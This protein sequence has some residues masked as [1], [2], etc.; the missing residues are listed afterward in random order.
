MH[1]VTLGRNWFDQIRGSAICVI[2]VTKPEVISATANLV[3]DC[4]IPSTVLMIGVPRFKDHGTSIVIGKLGMK[5]ESPP[6]IAEQHCKNLMENEE[7]IWVAP[8][9]LNSTWAACVIIRQQEIKALTMEVNEWAIMQGSKLAKL[10]TWNPLSDSYLLQPDNV[11]RILSKATEDFDLSNELRHRIVKFY[12]GLAEQ[13]LILRKYVTALKKDMRSDIG[14]GDYANSLNKTKVLSIIDP[15]YPRPM[16]A[17][18][19]EGKRLT[20]LNDTAMKPNGRSDDQGSIHQANKDELGHLNTSKTLLT[21]AG[22]E[23]RDRNS[24]DS[25]CEPNWSQGEYGCTKTDSTASN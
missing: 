13:A 18:I 12:A 25:I 16:D 2:L 20:D 22:L 7:M 14:H 8:R 17:L 19:R 6:E 5:P 15:G 4:A 23:T 9:V 21:V 10:L 3:D 24:L 1:N 11:D